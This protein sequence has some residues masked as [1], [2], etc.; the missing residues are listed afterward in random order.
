MSHLILWKKK[1]NENE[2]CYGNKK[3]DENEKHLIIE[4]F[5]YRK[6]YKVFY[7]QR[8]SMSK[9]DLTALCA[10]HAHIN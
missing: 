9:F 7:V 3:F 5:E 6:R 4:V 8:F 1:L 2:K 10:T